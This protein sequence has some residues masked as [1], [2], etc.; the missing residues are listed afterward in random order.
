MQMT[1]EQAI[2]TIPKGKHLF[3]GSGAAEPVGLVEELV[4]QADRFADNRI[5]PGDLWSRVR[6]GGQ[7]PCM[8]AERKPAAGIAQRTPG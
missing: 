3:V 6:S 2:S 4:T 5:V 7:N 1:L 8:G